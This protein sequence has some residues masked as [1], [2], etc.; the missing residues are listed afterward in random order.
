MSDDALTA[1]YQEIDQLFDKLE[2]DRDPFDEYWGGYTSGLA[3][4]L[5]IIDAH[6]GP[7]RQ[8]EHT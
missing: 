6:V 1:A 4:A 7:D 8:G 3:K 2:A 5:A